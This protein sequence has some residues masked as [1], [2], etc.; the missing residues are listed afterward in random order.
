MSDEHIVRMVTVNGARALGLGGQAG[1]LAPG[2]FADLATLPYAGTLAEVWEAVVRHRG[3]VAASMVD[4]E[5]TWR[6]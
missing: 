1:E 2:A 3:P 6:S 5:W 4:G